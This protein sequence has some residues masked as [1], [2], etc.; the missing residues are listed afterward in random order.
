MAIITV[1]D[2]PQPIEGR[3]GISVLKAAQDGN[4]PWR[5]FCGGRALCGTCAM[6]V[7]DGKVSEPTE[8]ERYFIEGWGYHPNFR[9]ACQTRAWGDVKV[10][11]CM[12][13]GYDPDSV[14]AAYRK[15]CGDAPE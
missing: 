11:S 1:V 13:E 12:D 6:V 10:I 4:A 14:V 3:D 7:V 5:S 9:L 8:I 2:R 15:A